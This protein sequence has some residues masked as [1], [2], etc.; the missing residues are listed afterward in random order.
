MNTLHTRKMSVKPLSI[1]TLDNTL[2]LKQ[3]D[4]QAMNLKKPK[5]LV[6]EDDAINQ[7]IAR[8]A[9]GEQ[10]FEVSVAQTGEEALRLYE[11][12]TYELILMDIGLPGQLQGT[13][14]TR[15][16]RT[17]EQSKAQHIPIIACTANPPSTKSAYLAVG[18]D[19]VISKPYDLTELK[20][21]VSSWLTRSKI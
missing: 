12:E 2:F 18:M 6:V 13:D 9:L 21:R 1:L 8:Y 7:T 11:T 19:D 14:V 4:T 3:R 10:D 16:I 20:Q 5:I 15:L 17:I